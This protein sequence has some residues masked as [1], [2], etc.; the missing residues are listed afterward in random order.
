ME[1]G[2]SVNDRDMSVQRGEGLQRGKLGP[3]R[4]RNL[5]RIEYWACLENVLVEDI[6]SN[7]GGGVALGGRPEELVTESPVLCDGTLVYHRQSNSMC[8]H[9]CT[10]RFRWHSRQPSRLQRL[11]GHRL[12]LRVQSIMRD[13]T[14]SGPVRTAAANVEP[15]GILATLDEL[16]G[17]RI[18]WYTACDEPNNWD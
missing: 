14:T 9:L 12:R 10:G 18:S 8:T 11:C 17:L 3:G 6:A 7:E 2:R 15:D 16:D 1:E 13:S 5:S 4:L